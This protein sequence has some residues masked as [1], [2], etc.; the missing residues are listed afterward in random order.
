MTFIKLV[1]KAYYTHNLF[2]P[3]E[4]NV[5][6]FISLFEYYTSKH[7]FEIQT[8]IHG[9]TMAKFR[10]TFNKKNPINS[11]PNCY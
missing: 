5:V 4:I 8:G 2:W 7:A 9:R 11:Q 6:L 3:T 1:F 10:F